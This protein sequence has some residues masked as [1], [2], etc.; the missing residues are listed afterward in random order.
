[1]SVRSGVTP[2]ERAYIEALKV[3]YTGKAEERSSAD[4]AYAN[5]MRTVHKRFPADRDAAT[6]FAESLMDLRPWNYWTRDGLPY[7]GTMEAVDTIESRP[8]RRPEPSRG[9]ALLDSPLGTDEDTRARGEGS[10]PP[11]SPHARCGARGS[12]AWP[13][14]PPCGPVHRRG[15]GERE[16]GRRRRGLHH[17]VQG[18]GALSARLLSAQHPLHLDGR[19]DVRAER[20]GDHC[21]TEGRVGDPAEAIAAAPPVQGFLAVPYYASIRFGKWDEILAEA[22]PAHDTIFIRGVWHFARGMAFSARGRPAE[23]AAELEAL[24]ADRRRPRAGDLRRSASPNPPDAILRIAPDV[25]GGEMRCQEQGRTTAPCCCSTAPCAMRTRS[26]TPSRPTGRHPVRQ[27]LGAALLEAGRPVEAEAVYWDDLKRYPENGWALF[28]L[29]QALTAQGKKAD[30][31][32]VQARFD[33]AWSA[34]DLKLTSSR[35]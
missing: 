19:D 29:V 27:R 33:K 30:A 7:D 11:G 25:L 9:A 4:L 28:G 17:A 32:R 23:A 2:R 8:G 26:S 15:Q 24:T 6:L 5:A 18:P 34:A 1:M 16:S 3:R 14:L 12:H 31:D 22:A 20:D 10:G 13:H 21:G 35:F